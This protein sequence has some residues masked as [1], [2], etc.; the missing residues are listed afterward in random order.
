MKSNCLRAAVIAA[1]LLMTAC[2]ES[3]KTS[4]T[5]NQSSG[6]AA[7]VSGK[8]AFWEM[9][10]S[11]HAWANDIV[12]LK[13][14]SKEIPGIKNDSGKA[15]MWSATFG[16]PRKGQAV[17][18]SYAITAHPPDIYKGVTADHPVTWAG[19]THDIMP[20]QN[21]DLQVDSDAAYQTALADAQP[22]L[23]KHQGKD[24]SFLLGNATR[25]SAP[26]WYVLWGDSKSGYS[27]YVNAVT[28]KV[29]KPGK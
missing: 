20:F 14:E 16:S 21:S 29:T 1:V 27:V 4:A 19:P 12:P 7:P 10:K 6:P 3:D 2:S 25:F 5:A 26:V 28:G 18:L 22:W 24:V 13:L 23:K 8:T 17:V 9:Y 15:A 11:A